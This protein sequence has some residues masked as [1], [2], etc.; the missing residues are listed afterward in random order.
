MDRKTKLKMIRSLKREI[1][2]YLRVIEELDDVE[3]WQETSAKINDLLLVYRHK[4]KPSPPELVMEAA[5]AAAEMFLEADEYPA[6]L[7]RG[8]GSV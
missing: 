2:E 3:L 6:W 5:H 4:G 7:M 1:L 8:K